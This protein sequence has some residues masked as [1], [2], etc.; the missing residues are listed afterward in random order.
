MIELLANEGLAGLSRAELIAQLKAAEREIGRQRARQVR[1]LREL[2]RRR[3][4]ELP[5]D[6]AG[7]AGW[8]DV[9]AQTA[10]ALLE[11]ARRTPEESRQ[12]ERL[13]GGTWSF[14]RADAMARLVAAGGDAA[15]REA[16]DD[17][18]IA[19][20]H[21]L[22]A[23]T[24]R[25]R[26]RDERQAHS[27]RFVRTH[28]SLDR[29][30]GFIHGQLAAYDWSIVA[31][32]ID[33]CADGFPREAK[34]ATSRDQRRADALVAIAQNWLDG[35]VGEGRAAPL[36]TVMVDAAAAA[37]TDCEAGVRL[38]GG[39]R[40]GPETL[41]RMLCEGAVEVVVDPFT[42][43]PLAVGPTTRVV[44]PKVRRFVV[45]RDGGCT[46]DGCTSRYRLE[47]HHIVPRSRGGSHD[48]SNLT[49][50]CWWHHQVAV[51]LQGYRIDPASPPGRRLLV[52]ARERGPP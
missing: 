13:E 32:A 37:Q 52:R 33:D 12:M 16:A 15:A 38:T 14:D 45:N 39:P 34:E 51:H 23:M 9:S 24:R 3:A 28:P 40:I 35:R 31:R 2:G 22:R 20:I 5:P 50:L 29:S 27:E 41:D 10:G 18:D 49:T 48:P 25:I 47:V 42:G 17:L 19:G 36:V 8:L 46:V 7:V 21:A 1:L 43:V 44:P 6:R 4:G 11:T 26:R 30:V